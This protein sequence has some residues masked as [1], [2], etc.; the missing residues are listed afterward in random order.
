MER[1]HIEKSG[2]IFKK[3]FIK[4]TFEN[5]ISERASY[6]ELLKLQLTFGGMIILDINGNY[7][8]YKKGAIA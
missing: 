4:M 7:L 6:E 2:D 8:F 5:E 1:I 3:I